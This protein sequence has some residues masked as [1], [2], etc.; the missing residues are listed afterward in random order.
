MQ[1]I[2]VENRDKQLIDSLF[3]I[4][5]K[6]VKATHTFLIDSEIEKI[7]KYMPDALINIPRLIIANKNSV[8]IAFMG[9][10]EQKVEVLFVSPEELGKGVG[11]QLLKYAI[12]KF[13]VKEL[14]VNEQ[15][16]KAKGF[17]EHMGFQV[18]KRSD[19]DEQKNPYPILYMKLS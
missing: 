5:K 15:N 18:Y 7:A 10:V 13:K 14:V 17:Y 4:W 11:K 9:I 16:P 2:L 3:N 19:L 12:E 1:I 8:P 6:S